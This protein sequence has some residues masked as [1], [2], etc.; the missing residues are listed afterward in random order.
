[1]FTVGLK[2]QMDFGMDGQKSEYEQLMEMEIED[3]GSPPWSDESPLLV[4]CREGNADKVLGLMGDSPL[5]IVDDRHRTCLHYACHGGDEATVGLI[6]TN[7]HGEALAHAQ[8]QVNTE[9]ST[10]T[11][12]S[13][14]ISFISSGSAVHLHSFCVQFAPISTDGALHCPLFWVYQNVL[15]I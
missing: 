5:Q 12:I 14:A 4:A 13:F 11:N 6:L 8:D 15:L 7:E 9:N 3:E 10:M 2:A 1:M